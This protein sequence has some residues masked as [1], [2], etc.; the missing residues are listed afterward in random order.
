[1]SNSSRFLLGFG[2]LILVIVAAA[3]IIA[4]TGSNQPIKILPENSPEG[5]VQ[6]FLTAV[7][8]R[9]YTKAYDFLA[10][11][12]GTDKVNTLDQW[13]QSTQYSRNTTSSWKASI[14]KSTITDDNATVEVAIDVFRPNGPFADPVSSNHITYL[15]QK[16]GDRW[17]I[18]QPVDLWWL[19]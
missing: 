5:T 1:M 13:V 10:P 7:K 12:T 9:D 16:V 6:R 4:V 17:L 8:D 14:V 15:L 11:Q 19:Y 18:E 2:I 3:V